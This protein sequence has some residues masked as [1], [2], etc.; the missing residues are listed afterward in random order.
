MQ[1]SNPS[2]PH[3][4]LQKISSHVHNG[5]SVTGHGIRSLNLHAMYHKKVLPMGQLC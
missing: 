1:N 3:H 2:Q 5:K 4:A